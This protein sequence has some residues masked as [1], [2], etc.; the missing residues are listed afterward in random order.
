MT[1]HIVL[2]GDK[3]IGVFRT[4]EAAE[5]LYEKLIEELGNPIAVR[6]IAW[7]TTD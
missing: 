2:A 5:A 3:I 7:T 1:V 6:N 4:P